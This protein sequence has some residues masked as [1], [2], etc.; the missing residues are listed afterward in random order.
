MKKNI[1]LVI[2]FLLSSM[3]IQAQQPRVDTRTTETKIA[4]LI[5]KLPAQSSASLHQIM[6]ELSQLGAPVIAQ[7]VPS[8]VPPGKGDDTQI[9]YAISEI[10]RAHV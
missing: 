1:L 3:A 9:R 6:S 5:M 8:L 2:L 10:G 4:D 7:L